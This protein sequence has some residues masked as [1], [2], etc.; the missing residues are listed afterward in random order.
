MDI[1]DISSQ[2]NVSILGAILSV[3]FNRPDK[4]NS[5]TFEMYRSLIKLFDRA[6]KDND[7]GAVVL[8]GNGGNFSAGNDIKDFVTII[9]KKGMHRH[10]DAPLFIDTIREFSKP[11]IAAVEGFAVGIGVTLLLYCDLVYMSED[12]KLRMPFTQLGLCPEAAASHI[13]PKIMGRARAA[14]WLMLGEVMTAQQAQQDGLV[15]R[16][17]ENPLK[18]ALEKAEILSKMSPLA[19]TE[20]KR[21]ISFDNEVLRKAFD[22]EMKSFSQCLESDEA[23]QALQDFLDK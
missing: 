11:V 19:V 3:K 16:I 10:H 9:E 7:I 6:E 15:T 18:I 23:R 21:L 1:S 5:F 2:L 17:S 22:E 20:T 8:S 4:M 14:E 12:A 13:L